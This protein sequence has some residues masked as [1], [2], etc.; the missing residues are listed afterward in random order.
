MLYWACCTHSCG[1]LLAVVGDEGTQNTETVKS[2]LL[3]LDILIG[4]ELASGKE[5]A[6]YCILW[7]YI[8][9]SISPFP[10]CK[11]HGERSWFEGL[12]SQMLARLLSYA[13][14]WEIFCNKNNW[15]FS[16]KF[17]LLVPQ[18]TALIM[19][20]PRTGLLICL[21][22]NLP[23]PIEFPTLSSGVRVLAYALL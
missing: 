18:Y 2:G 15:E 21:K 20:T 16:K 10:N 5:N 22:K 13:S 19:G 23:A 11:P 9:A 1:G 7:G 4:L 12:N 14:L 6:T 17:F 3:P 8:W